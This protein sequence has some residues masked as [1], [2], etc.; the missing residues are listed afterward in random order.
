MSL[1][2]WIADIEVDR[3]VNAFRSSERFQNDAV[4]K[5]LVASRCSF[6]ALSTRSTHTKY[7]QPR[8][9][10]MSCRENMPRCYQRSTYYIVLTKKNNERFVE[11][12]T[13]L[14]FFFMTKIIYGNRYLP[15]LNVMSFTVP[16]AMESAVI[17]AV[18]PNNTKNGQAPE[19]LTKWNN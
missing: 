6:C 7:I 14:I 17:G 8:I 15:H 19:I 16:W 12:M 9:H 4:I 13:L 5:T 3:I 1:L 11:L 2:N 10:A 18:Y